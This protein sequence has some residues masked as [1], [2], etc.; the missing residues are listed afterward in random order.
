MDFYLI[1]K[2][3]Q[4]RL[5]VLIVFPIIAVICAVILVL[6]MDKVYKSY[7]HLATGFTADDAV[8]LNDES[9]NSYETNTRFTNV[10]ES[11]NSLPVLSLVSYKL[12]LHDLESDTPY[13]GLTQKQKEKLDFPLTP[14]F[15][16]KAKEILKARANEIKPLNTADQIDYQL[17]DLL[18]A[19]EYDYEALSEKF[20]IKRLTTSDF[21][22]VDFSSESPFLSAD[23][24]NMLCSE[25]IRYNKVLK[26][27]R[28]S[29]SLE[30]LEGVVREKKRILDEKEALLNDYKVNNNVFN[31]GA[32]SE[33]KISQITEYELNKE[34]EEKN[35]N[36]LRLEKA[37]LENRLQNTTQLNQQEVVQI[38]QRIID[39]RRKISEITN[40]GTDAE[41]ATLGK[42]RDE[43]QLE[44]S[45]LDFLNESKDKDESGE[46]KK[47]YDDV[48]L[49]LQI[50]ETNLTAADQ[51][52]RRLK[53]DVSGFATKEA[54]ISELQRDVQVASEEYLDAQD[55]YSSAKNK[56][57][58]VGSSIRQI[59][60]AQP[61]REPEPSKGILIVALAGIGSFVF[62]VT[63]LLLIEFADMTIR[64]PVRLE[65]LT[66]LSTIGSLNLIKIKGF[67]L[68]KTFASKAGDKESNTFV[69]FLRKL[70]Y[71]VQKSDGKVFLVSSTQPQV[72]KS[73]MIICLS[74][75]L[76]LVNKKVLIIDTNF[77][78]NS[79][80]KLLLP[81][82]DSRR[83]LKRGVDDKTLLL[84]GKDAEEEETQEDNHNIIYKTEFKGVD[85][86]GNIG[87]TD[88][89]S[90]ILAGRDFKEMIENLSLQYDYIFLEGPSIN[91]YSDSKELIDYV[92]KV[93]AVFDANT[94]LN[95]L[96]KE[97]INYLKSI[98]EKLLG[99][100]L[101]KVQL[102]D[103]SV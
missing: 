42:L 68:R 3:L 35:V 13:R 17:F 37:T 10:I 38:N 75:T 83:L 84:N 40:S 31:Y 24:V 53:Y 47:Q 70:R 55:K 1:L 96:D 66:G 11:M 15:L 21:I 52:L 4:R 69:H 20:T 46:L 39:L 81:V 89:P 2:T 92:D 72:G 23:A 48:K 27:D 100:V 36:A 33:S 49:K 103:L 59:L 7:A 58:V 45:R 64:I 86:I 99:S 87:G 44:I 61:S 43:L 94:N 54:K 95:H 73:F 80:T 78:R 51:S 34:R 76:S 102:K 82:T 71:E 90:E 63:I 101:N 50:A 88:S 93:I 74:Y 18:K 97:S 6:R 25:F 26:G 30:F 16:E 65:R 29:E 85:I 56:A 22:S 79:L 14:A 91:E 98:K 32:E 19:Y 9:S 28:S 5:W 67:D 12:M 8:K 41:R 77:K 60:E 57:L 62:C